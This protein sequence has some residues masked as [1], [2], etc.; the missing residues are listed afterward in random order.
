MRT[1]IENNIAFV[2]EEDSDRIDRR[3]LSRMWLIR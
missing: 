2:D 3:M 1:F